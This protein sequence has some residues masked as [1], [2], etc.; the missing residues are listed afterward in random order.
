MSLPYITKFVINANHQR[1]QP[2]PSHCTMC[3]HV[4]RHL[5]LLLL[6]LLP[7]VE[8]WCMRLPHRPGRPSGVDHASVDDRRT[9]SNYP[10]ISFVLLHN[11]TCYNNSTV[12]RIYV[13]TTREWTQIVLT[14]PL[15]YC[16]MS[17]ATIILH[18]HA[19]ML[20]LQE[21]ELKLSSHLLCV[22]AQCHLLQ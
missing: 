7:L 19:S 22:T 3:Q 12:S 11:V 2:T 1:S 8:C 21:N 15:C 4:E 16:T 10:H 9:N 6:L 17:F 20:K 14:S 5:L 18:Y 13:N